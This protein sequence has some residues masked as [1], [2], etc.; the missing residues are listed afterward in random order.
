MREIQKYHIRVLLYPFEDRISAISGDIE[1]SNVKLRR[2]MS[3]LLRL[4]GL[5]V[6]S[7]QVLMLNRALQRHN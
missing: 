1:V 5:Q 2:Q 3:K 7:P 4:A 6:D